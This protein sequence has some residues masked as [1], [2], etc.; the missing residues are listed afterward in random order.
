MRLSSHVKLAAIA[1]AFALTIASV[2]G[3][4]SRRDVVLYNHTPSV[5]VGLYLR[6]DGP[7]T[8]GAFVTVR[9]AEVAPAAARAR[10]FEDRRDRFI[11]RVTALGG[12][13]VCV[14]AEEIFINH[15]SIARRRARDS[16]GAVL[17]T[18]D[19]CRVLTGDEVLLLGDTPDSFDGR[20]W[21]PVR[22][23]QIEGVWRPLLL[24]P[25]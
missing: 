16:T 7:V 2:M 22:L 19:G 15:V 17:Q 11:K 23:A 21:G 20:Y 25:P 3:Q 18:W 13:H 12:D 6:T 10:N 5:P 14:R 4:P 8:L 24:S 1:G 9:A